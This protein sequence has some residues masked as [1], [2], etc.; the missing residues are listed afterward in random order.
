MLKEIEQCED[1]DGEILIVGNTV[2]IDDGL[3]SGKITE[4]WNNGS[5]D[6]AVAF[7]HQ[8]PVIDSFDIRGHNIIKFPEVLSP[9]Q[10]IS[11]EKIK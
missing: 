11:A 6:V 9:R 7:A 4:I 10:I 3:Q 2:I 5:I 1:V 8:G